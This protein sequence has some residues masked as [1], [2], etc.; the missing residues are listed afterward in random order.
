MFSFDTEL[1]IILNSFISGHPWLINGAVFFAIYVPYLLIVALIVF[2]FYKKERRDERGHV[3][4]VALL[5]ALIAR[6]PLKALIVLGYTFSR[7][8]VALTDITL[9]I[10][11]ILTEEYFSF[12]SGHTLFFFAAAT[13]VYTYRTKLGL[14]FFAAA[15]C[16][17][18]ARVMVGVHYPTDI[19]GGMILGI[20]VGLIS[21]KLISFYESRF[22]S[23]PGLR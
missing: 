9:L 21:S 7:P 3:A 12:P 2:V 8:Y 22:G 18:I 6:Y 20:L 14:I 15:L 19:L 16:M 10:P 5:A 13:V 23:H 1:A 17:G 4:L 11:P